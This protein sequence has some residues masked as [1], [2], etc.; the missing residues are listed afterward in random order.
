MYLTAF[1]L[2]ALTL[3][4]PSLSMASSEDESLE[5]LYGDD[6]FISIATGR[7]QL[8][9]KAAAVASVI[10]AEDIK[11]MGAK[12]IEQAL[13]S[14]AGLHV[15]RGA[16]N[17]NSVFTIRGIGSGANTQ[18][19]MLINGIP[20]TNVFT[21]DRSIVWGGMPVQNISRIEV[22]RGPGSAVYGADAFSGTINIITKTADEI[23]GFET[24]FSTG[25]FDTRHA[26]ALFGGEVK[27]WDVAFSMELSDSKGHDET[28]QSDFQS[29]LDGLLTTNASLAPG[30]V[31]TG[32]K[33]LETRIDLAKDLWRLRMGF[34]GRYDV[35]T[36]AGVNQSLDLFGSGESERL[37]LDLTYHDANFSENWDLQGTLSFF[38]TGFK[39]SNIHLL[40]AGAFGGA[41]PNGMIGSPAVYERHYR[42]DMSAFFTGFNA[43]DIRVGAGVY[44]IDQY[45][46][47]ETKNFIFN[48]LPTPPTPMPLQRV[49]GA[50]LFNREAG[51]TINYVLV[52]DEWLF[53]TDWALTTGLR[54][55]HYSDFGGTVNPR[56]ALIYNSPYNV[57]TKF[58]YGRAFRAPAFAEQF[59][60]NNPVLI[61]N[62]DLDPEVIDS[63]EIVVNYAA[64][65][66]LRMDL[67]LFYYEMQ[68]II[69]SAPVAQNT[70]NQTGYGA[71]WEFEWGVSDKLT[72]LGNYAYQHSEDEN[73]HCDVA[74]VP[75]Q[76]AYLRADYQVAPQ[77]S[78]FTQV[79]RVMDR[80]R[81]PG[82]TRP[83][84]EDYT[85]VD[86]SLRAENI[87][88]NVSVGFSVNNLTDENALEPSVAPGNIANDLPL[89]GLSLTAEISVSW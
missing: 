57:T 54:Y 26:W 52:Q 66:D 4:V 85:T 32:K 68:G 42:S 56:M 23:D 61:G 15:S 34:Q 51:R 24:G 58:L 25:S 63:Y 47:E 13:E 35:G 80:K 27:G 17:Y 77:W 60:A 55:D 18:V 7:K 11:K 43:H 31:N 6:S 22:I 29:V 8:L 30:G 48:T 89:A 5:L 45:R 10:T 38:Q 59:N 49:S 50:D 78:L 44:Y 36:G 83:E 12:D 88:P 67:N 64:S 79:N 71:E 2:I 65:P 40:P 82:D 9:S 74:D 14:V 21:G 69:I 84:V 53:A 86:V 19:L 37:N 75:Q 76:Q 41:F 73:N 87:F 62:E 33:S 70:G 16:V 20:I 28:V 46:V 3:L 81:A 1:S 72:L 39:T